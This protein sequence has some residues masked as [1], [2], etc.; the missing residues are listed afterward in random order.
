MRPHSDYR[1]D[2]L[3]TELKTT[4]ALRD[5]GVLT[6]TQAARR[7]ESAVKTYYPADTLLIDYYSAMAIYSESYDSKRIDKNELADL[8]DAKWDAYQR[9]SRQRNEE[10]AAASRSAQ[11]EVSIGSMLNAAAQGA[12]RAAQQT[13]AARTCIYSPA[14]VSVV[15]SCY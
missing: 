10:I 15:Q 4:F 5:Q 8:I 1:A 9:S 2:S 11:A 14:G 13:P 12:N 6:Y 7:A 3:R